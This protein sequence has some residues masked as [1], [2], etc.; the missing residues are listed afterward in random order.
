MRIK[1]TK[2][3]KKFKIL[4]ILKGKLREKNVYNFETENK[5]N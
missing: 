5:E 1:I 2:Y 4:Q 3:S